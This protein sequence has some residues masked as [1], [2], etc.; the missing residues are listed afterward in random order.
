MST[1]RRTGKTYTLM[2]ADRRLYD[3]PVP[4]RW[5]GH[6]AGRIYGRLDCPAALRAI[7]SG[8]YISNRVFFADEDTA[9]AAGYRPCDTCLRAKYRAWK[10]G[11]DPRT[12]SDEESRTA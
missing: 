2:G 9:L 6:R 7:A 10:A 5:G 8:G 12:V 3:S 1:P 4:G 11:G